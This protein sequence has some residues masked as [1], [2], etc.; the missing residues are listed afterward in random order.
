MQAFLESMELMGTGDPLAR[1]DL[2]DQMEMTA[3]L[4]LGYPAPQELM[5]YKDLQGIPVLLVL[6]A[7]RE[8][9]EHQDQEDCQEL[10]QMEKLGHLE[11]M[12]WMGNLGRLDHREPGVLAVLSDYL[13]L[14]DQG[15]HLESGLERICVPLH[16]PL[17]CLATPASQG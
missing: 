13:D 4:A 17:A 6:L 8:I 7:Q 10:D 14:L 9:A 16:A 1:T 3:N 11:L 15:V 12:A 2:M 5:A